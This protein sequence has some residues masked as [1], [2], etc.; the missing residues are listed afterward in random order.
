MEKK[1]Q[2][3]IK[4]GGIRAAIWQNEVTRNGKTEL[5]PSVQ[6]DRTYKDSSGA[7]QRTNKFGVRDLPRLV[8]VAQKAYERL[9]LDNGE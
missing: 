5:V 9:V 6:I 1:P 7:W 3:V 4:A 8:V 2:D